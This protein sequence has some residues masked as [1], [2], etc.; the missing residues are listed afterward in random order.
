[1][2]IA[3][4]HTARRAWRRPAFIGL[5]ALSL[6]A[7]VAVILD[8]GSGWWLLLAFGLGPDLALLLGAGAGLERGNCTRGPCLST[9]PCTATSGP[10]CWRSPASRSRP[11]PS[12]PRSPGPSTSPSTAPIG[13]GMRTRDGF[14]RS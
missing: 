11:A 4:P 6:A 14:Q 10:R 12:S 5:T 3:H 7:A 9:T 13:Y 2:Q 8:H 1:M